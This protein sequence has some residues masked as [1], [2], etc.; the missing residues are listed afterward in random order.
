VAATE[1]AG[2]VVQREL[3]ETNRNLRRM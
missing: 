3:V 2:A 1:E